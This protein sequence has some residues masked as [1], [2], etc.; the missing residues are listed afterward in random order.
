MARKLKV[1]FTGVESFVKCSEGEH[2]AVLKEIKEESAKSSGSDMLAC[3][4]EVIKGSSTGAR[5]YDNFVL[6]DKALWKLKGYL[7]VV[8]LKADGKIM[9]DLDKMVGKTCIISVSHEEYNGSKRAR[10]EEY[11][12]LEASDDED[13]DD[14]DDEE[15]DDEPAETPKQKKARLAKAAAEAKAKKGKKKPEPEEDDEDD[16]DDD[17]D[18]EEEE[19]PKE[20]KARLAK[21][22]AAKDKKKGKKKP[23]DD[24]DEDDWDE[25]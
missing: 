4:F 10:I 11:K 3:V 2:I 15:E 19:T 5:V 9:I 17:D 13:V 24:E 12:K 18:E 7:E 14:D 8:G 20:K 6:T 23:A 21:E 1:N 25:A 22:K 16:E